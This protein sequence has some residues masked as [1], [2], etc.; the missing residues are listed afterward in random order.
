MAAKVKTEHEAVTAALSKAVKHAL[1]AGAYLA[2]AK[3]NLKHGQWLPWLETCEISRRT[4]QLYM[5]L[6][7]HRKTIEKELRNPES[8]TTGK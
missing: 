2:E 8:G 6:H 4:A 7:R 3:E 5:Q 1:N